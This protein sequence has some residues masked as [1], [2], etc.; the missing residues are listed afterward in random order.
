MIHHNGITEKQVEPIGIS[1]FGF[2]QIS[3]LS[4]RSLSK[5]I[6]SVGFV[7][8][9]IQLIHFP[10][11]TT[12]GST[13]HA[14]K[15]QITF[16]THFFINPHLVLRIHQ[17]KVTVRRLHPHS[18]LTRVTQPTCTCLTLLSSNN[19]HTRHCTRSVNRSCRTVF[20]YLK[21]LNV[22]CIQPRNSRTNQSNRISR[23]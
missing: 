6:H 21:T 5:T 17:V 11:H 7:I 3:I 12:I 19:N 13:I 16:I 15:V 1:I 4:F 8:P 18:K 9:V 22:I 20:Q 2:A 14:G 10:I 23:R